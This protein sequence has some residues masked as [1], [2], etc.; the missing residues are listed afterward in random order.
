MGKLKSVV[1]GAG[2]LC[3]VLFLGLTAFKAEKDSL[4]KR[5]FNVMLDEVKEGV[6]GKDA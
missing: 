2:A 3:F 5:T 6:P 4:H 1:L